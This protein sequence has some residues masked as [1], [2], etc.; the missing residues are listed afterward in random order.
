MAFLPIK[1]D[2]EGKTALLR[3]IEHH[4]QAIESRQDQQSQSIIMSLLEAKANP[5][6]SRSLIAAARSSSEVASIWITEKLLEASHA[7][8]PILGIPCL[9]AQSDATG[10]TAL[11]WSI[12]NQYI[13][14]TQLL[15]QSRANVNKGDFHHN[16]PLFY[17]TK[18]NCTPLI[19][20]LLEARADVA[21]CNPDG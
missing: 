20:L 21:T 9:L 14:L 16:T 7:L 10:K 4:D 2:D 6:L 13:Q 12:Q 15:I 8:E 1:L 17:A 11:I 3:A 19:E 18:A 5:S